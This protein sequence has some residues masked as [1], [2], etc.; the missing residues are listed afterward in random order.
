MAMNTN[1]DSEWETRENPLTD[2]LIVQV[3]GVPV[4]PEH[5]YGV[6]TSWF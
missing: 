3:E 1:T 6:I 4:Q 2:S 5:D